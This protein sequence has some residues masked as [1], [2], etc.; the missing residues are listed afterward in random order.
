[1]ATGTRMRFGHDQE[2]EY[3]IPSEQ[4]ALAVQL[5]WQCIDGVVH[6]AHQDGSNPVSV[7]AEIGQAGELTFDFDG[8]RAWFIRV[9]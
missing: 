1:M 6:T 8:T 4:G 5:R 2:L 3:T 7:R 9:E